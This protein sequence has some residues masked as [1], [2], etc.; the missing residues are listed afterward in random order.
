VTTLSPDE[1][2]ARARSAI[3]AE[4]LR[5]NRVMNLVTRQDTA[6]Q[7]DRLLAQCLAG[8]HLAAAAVG[9]LGISLDS[10][11]YADV[12]SGNGLPG[13]LWAAGLAAAG[14]HG[15]YW[16]VEPRERRAWFLSHVAREE[17]LPDLTV[18]AGRWGAPLG[19]PSP[20][21]N[22]L[23][24]LKALRLTEPEVL[25]GLGRGLGAGG[26]NPSPPQH[27]VIVRFLGPD[28]AQDAATVRDLQIA[29]A[30]TTDSRQVACRVLQDPSVRLLMTAYD[31]T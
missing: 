31:R 23:V 13:L 16:L 28:P 5:W 14:G 24:S 9:D 17:Y 6:R 18:V 7:L 20:P 4:I 11:G 15:P 10:F 21:G 19:G 26:S 30:A 27:V 3:H 25:A 12:G 29:D 8:F 2:L 22:L 1:A